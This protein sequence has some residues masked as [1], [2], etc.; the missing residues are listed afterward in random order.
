METCYSENIPQG[1][2]LVIGCKRVQDMVRPSGQG[3]EAHWITVVTTK[4]MVENLYVDGLN[5]ELY[6]LNVYDKYNAII[7]RIY[8][9]SGSK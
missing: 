7:D 6:N 9:V 2:D 4:E 8:L 5:E 1:S 3:T